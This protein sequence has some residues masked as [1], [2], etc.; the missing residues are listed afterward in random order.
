MKNVSTLLKK[1]YADA[2]FTF[3]LKKDLVYILNNLYIHIG[4]TH[5]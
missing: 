2:Y 1:N 4:K 3:E 5:E